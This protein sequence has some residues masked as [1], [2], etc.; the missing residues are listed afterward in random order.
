MWEGGGSYVSLRN[1]FSYRAQ[2]NQNH[3]R[4]KVHS[5]LM[6]NTGQTNEHPFI[7]FRTVSS[8]CGGNMSSSAEETTVVVNHDSI[9]KV[10]L[11]LLCLYR[12]EFL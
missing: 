12:R 6:Y 8:P 11:L 10:S 7:P 5:W 3:L 9:S 4:S 1:A 2:T